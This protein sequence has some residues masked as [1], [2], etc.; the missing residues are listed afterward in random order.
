MTD[1]DMP[2]EHYLTDDQMADYYADESAI[3]G[4]NEAG[5]DD[6]S[7]GEYNV[8]VMTGELTDF[9]DELMEA[10]KNAYDEA[11]STNGEY[12]GENS[13]QDENGKEVKLK[14][15]T[16]HEFYDK[17]LRFLYPVNIDGIKTFWQIDW[18]NNFAANERITALWQA[19]E[20]MH[21]SDLSAWFIHHADPQMTVLQSYTGP[22]STSKYIQ[23]PGN[24]LPE[25]EMPEETQS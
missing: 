14:Y 20:Q 2:D 9:L 24:P 13:V 25:L 10:E 23:Y 6:E 21:T 4:E 12:G 15:A 7:T 8:D 5:Y 18:A 17:Y 3:S 16:A 1:T 19:Y 22:F 11:D